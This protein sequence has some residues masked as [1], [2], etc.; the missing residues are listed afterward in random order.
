[1]ASIE[2]T[3]YNLSG[4]NHKPKA[5]MNDYFF[6]LDDQIDYDLLENNLKMFKQI[7]NI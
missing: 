5:N 2:N 4:L 7:N 6:M 3:K 1:M